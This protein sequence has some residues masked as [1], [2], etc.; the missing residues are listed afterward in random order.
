MGLKSIS[1]TFAGIR[2]KNPVMTAS[3]T[4][5][6]GTEYAGLIDL[7]K[8]GAIVTKTVTLLPRAGNDQ[9]RIHEL[10]FGMINSIGLQNV[11]LEKFLSEKLPA[12]KKATATPVIVSIG[13]SSI[14]EYARIARAL[15]GAPVSGIE[16]N[17][18]CPNVK[19]AY[20]KDT[21][22][23]LTISQDPRKTFDYV[24]AVKQKTRLP[25]IVKLSPSVTDI[26]EIARSAQSAGADALALTN[27]FPAMAFTDKNGPGSPSVIFGGLSGPCLKP[28]ALRMVHAVC[29]SVKIPVLG[30]GGI[31][32]GRDALD[33][34]KAGAKA[35]AVGTGNFVDPKIIMS[36]I[37]D[38]KKAGKES[39]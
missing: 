31:M 32:N 16:L 17:I 21:T 27:T 1:M 7:E 4:F 39:R 6:Y 28:M 2:M 22:Q 34:L 24:K 15:N 3:G 30:M 37:Q 29:R 23:Y 5:G 26:T 19:T 18:S 11:G 25:L 38:L 9:P 10:P 33:F 12:L 8:L 20:K 13:G 35:V 36:I 14:R